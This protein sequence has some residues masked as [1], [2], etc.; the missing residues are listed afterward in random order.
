MPSVFLVS[1]THFGHANICV[2]TDDKGNKIR[3]WDNVG[4]MHKDMIEYWNDTVKPTDKVYCL[5]DMVIRRQAFW[6]LDK[7]HGD[8]VLIKGNHDIFKLKDYLPYFR[9]IRAYHVM[10]KYLLS[11]IPVHV[12]SLGRFR[13][14]IHGHTHQNHVLLPNKQRDKRYVNVCVEQTDFRPILFEEALKRFE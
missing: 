11:H 2:F 13:G 12:E 6:V 10:N 3:P 14:N 4:D 7:L 8:K 9:D 5:G 1:D